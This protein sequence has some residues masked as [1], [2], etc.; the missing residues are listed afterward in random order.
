MQRHRVDR[1]SL[2]QLTDHCAGE[3]RIAI[4]ASN[5]DVD[6]GRGQRATTRPRPDQLAR[7]TRIQWPHGDLHHPF[8]NVLSQL[9]RRAPGPTSDQQSNR[10][11][12]DGER[13]EERGARFI[14]PMH[15]LHDQHGRLGHHGTKQL[16]QRRVDPLP[17]RLRIDGGRLG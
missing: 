9:E 2:D 7:P 11:I 17:A 8:G 13:G 15:V 3:Q 5:D 6:I 12:G 14:A 1:A 10:E 16:D 4:G